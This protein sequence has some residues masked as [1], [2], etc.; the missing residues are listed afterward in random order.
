MNTFNIVV[1]TLS[2]SAQCHTTAIS[3][4]YV[5]NHL[6]DTTIAATGRILNGPEN[7]NFKTLV[8]IINFIKFSI[9]ELFFKDV[10]DYFSFLIKI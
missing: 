10:T 8:M 3:I 6:S 5:H 2:D 7:R 1:A 4:I 9:T